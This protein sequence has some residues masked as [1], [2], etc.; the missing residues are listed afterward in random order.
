MGQANLFRDAAAA[1]VAVAVLLL[2]LPVDGWKE[3]GRRRL[4]TFLNIALS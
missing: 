1:G 2:L 3:E 4:F